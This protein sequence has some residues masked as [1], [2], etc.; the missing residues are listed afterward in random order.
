MILSLNFPGFLFL[1]LALLACNN[2][3]FSGTFIKW[4]NTTWNLVVQ[5]Y[6]SNF[7]NADAGDYHEQ[8][9]YELVSEYDISPN[10]I[11]RLKLKQKK[12][13]NNPL[14]IKMTFKSR[15]GSLLLPVPEIVALFSAL[16]AL[17]W[18][19]DDDSGT[20]Y[21]VESTSILTTMEILGPTGRVLP[22]GHHLSTFC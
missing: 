7:Q 2:S 21:A 3:S 1:L 11:V 18:R 12:I 5:T 19:Q 6:N 14:Y 4:D 17:S 13:M 10:R 20:K 9:E 22:K 15:H 8:G 16:P